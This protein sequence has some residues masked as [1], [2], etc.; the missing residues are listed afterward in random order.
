MTD[1]QGQPDVLV[2]GA[3]VSGAAL[4]HAAAA[5]GARVRV[6]EAGPRP[7]GCLASERLE[8]G[9]W[10]ELGAHTL[11]N[12]YGATIEALEA[13]G[14]AGDLVPRAKPVLRLLEGDRVL[15]GKNLGLLLGQMRKLQLVAA[16]PRWIGASPRGRTVREHFG[17]LVGPDNYRRVLGPMLSA[18]PSQT[19]DDLPADLLFKKRP[20][21]KDVRRSFTLPRGLGTLVEGLL[22]PPG[23]ELWTDAVAVAVAR[24]GEGF[25]VDLAD[26]RRVEAPRLVLA[27]P[28]QAT[29]GLLRGAAPAV[30]ELA[31][32]IG[33]A[34]A[35]SLGFAVPAEASPLPRATFFI[36]RDDALLSVVTRDVVPDPQ[37]RG[38][39]LHFRPG[40][41]R[42]ERL[43][44][45]ARLVGIAPEAFEGLAERRTLLPAP[46]RG[47][48]E[49]V[50][51][52]DRALAGGP[53]GL[54]GNWFGGLSIED[55]VLRSR[56]EWSRLAAQTGA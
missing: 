3:G 8:S 32:G 16:L 38:F 29:A 10:F 35:D 42:D 15:P 46:R 50:A 1:G 26:G 39:T 20:R 30:A 24:T 28:P 56:S 51:A 37:R 27:L 45:A 34:T 11:Y 33:E 4:A 5:S 52:L 44:R 6:L 2:V 18:V 17:R 14:L 43:E 54:T 7:G 23:V 53:L 13:L 48:A 25:A 31:G 47:H 19:A 9:F 12:S 21:R 41:G 49:R 36:P 55:C 22:D 40:L